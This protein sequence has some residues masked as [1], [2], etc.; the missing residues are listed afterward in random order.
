M[1]HSKNRTAI[2][3]D[4]IWLTTG[5]A[6][7]LSL[8][9]MAAPRRTEPQQNLASAYSHASETPPTPSPATHQSLRNIEEIEPGQTVLARDPATGELAPREVAHV[10]R[11]L[12]DHLRIVEIRAADGT[13]VQTIK[14]TD[15]HP[16]WVTGKG[17]TKASTLQPGDHLQQSD[18]GTAEVIATRYESH[19]EGIP[20]YNIEVDDF[21]T[22]YVAAHGTRAPPIWVHNKKLSD[23]L[24]RFVK[25]ELGAAGDLKSLRKYRKAATSAGSDL[26]NM[27][28]RL[29]RLGYDKAN[30][31]RIIDAI[32]RGEEVVVV[33]ENMKRVKAVANMI[34]NAGG[35]SVTYAP[36]NWTGA[37]RNSLE[38]NR[39]WI[40]YWAGEKGAT[41]VDIGR[42][43]TPRPFGPSPYYGME[44]RSLQ[45]MDVYTPFQE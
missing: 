4:K 2:G 43:S 1:N 25:E 21:H 30:T 16:F 14:T 23:A 45:R 10:I 42:Q 35:A 12:S 29:E 37:S 38:A 39:S 24:R 18:S 9:A 13:E 34:D 20:V 44:N 8:L 41:V 6:L 32:E 28:Q 17:W 19:P 27:A 7:S 15:E 26:A 40:R 22:Y 5:I 31:A 36:R 33:G 11:T 3:W